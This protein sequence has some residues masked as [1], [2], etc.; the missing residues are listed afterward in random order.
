MESITLDKLPSLSKSYRQ[1]I[2]GKR[3]KPLSDDGFPNLEINLPGISPDPFMLEKF[4]KLCNSEPLD[5]LPVTFPYVM[6][7]PLH[8]Y[9]LSHPKFPVKAAG[10]LHLR[11]RI[12]YLAK[13]PAYQTIDL[14]VKTSECRYR[15]QGF[16]F[17]IITSAKI[18]GKEH[19]VCKSTFL[20]KGN[21]SKED[22]ASED[23]E[24]FIKLEKESDGKSFKV[25]GNAGR[26]Y[27]GL[28]KD[29]NPIHI[30][31]PLAWL[32]GFK[33]SIAHGM[34]IAARSLSEMAITDIKNFDLAFKG[35]VFTGSKVTI[36]KKKEHFNLFCSG[37]SRPV[38][39]GRVS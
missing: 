31:T 12:E 7:G 39:L 25:P 37:N 33:K 36:V 1:L 9:L 38:I 32:F 18:N 14:T 29:Y 34:W 16:E 4:L 27:A 20:K 15:P 10:L 8:L 24:L 35:P 3:Q 28:C 19:W 13:I 22:P 23:E 11:N 21:F 30:F 5:S 17:E 2:F 26:Q 6:A